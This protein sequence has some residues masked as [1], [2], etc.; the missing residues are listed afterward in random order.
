[1][2]ISS[3]SRRRYLTAAGGAVLAG[4]LN[5]P[6]AKADQVNNAVSNR[7]HILVRPSLKEK[8]TACFAD[9]LGCGAPLQLAA[10][11]K[12]EPLLAFRFPAGG[13]ISIEFTEDA[14]DEKQARRGAW[15]E[16]KSDDP[17][18]LKKRILDAGLERIEYWATN[19]FYFV[20]PGGQVFGI[21]QANEMR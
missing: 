5:P 10:P 9:T 6:P 12:P 17:A 1:M 8:L 21:S 11:G 7:V 13:S 20:V 16:V 19:N 3:V 4:A 2:T 18:A 15:L 14:L